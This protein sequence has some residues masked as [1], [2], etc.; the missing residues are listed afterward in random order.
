MSLGVG[1]HAADG[2][3][4]GRAE[5]LLNHQEGDEAGQACGTVVVVGEADGGADGKEPRHVVDESAARLDEQ[6][7][8]GVRRAGGLS[9][10]NAHDAGGEQIADAHEDAGDRKRRDGKHQ[11]LA[12]LLQVLHHSAYLLSTGLR[13]EPLG[14]AS[15]L[16]LRRRGRWRDQAIKR[17]IVA[18]CMFKV[19]SGVFGLGL[20]RYLVTVT[21]RSP[22]LAGPFATGATAERSAV[23]VMTTNTVSS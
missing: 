4:D 20:P 12:E 2:G 8:G 5:K 18:I 14:R 6:E 10:R 7:A 16:A 11:R 3:D 13:H 17:Q 15:P 19:A 22:A 21:A 23:L 9:A 1:V